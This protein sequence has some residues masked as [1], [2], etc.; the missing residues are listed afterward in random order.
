MANERGT[1]PIQDP[2]PV[3]SNVDE[4]PSDWP[5]IEVPDPNGPPVPLKRHPFQFTLRS[6]MVGTLAC[7]G[8][9]AVL[10]RSNTSNCMGA[11]RSSKLEW[12]Y[13]QWEI[14]QAESA[15]GDIV[16]IESLGVVQPVA[17]PDRASGAES[18]LH[19]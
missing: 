3:P 5:R 14:E 17:E 16:Q 8:V 18:E 15:L 1:N 6:L 11:T 12:D 4:A 19:D 7:G 13:R 10:S 9:F 2:I